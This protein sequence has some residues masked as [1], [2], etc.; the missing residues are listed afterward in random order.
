MRPPPIEQVV[1]LRDEMAN[2]VWAVERIV[3][4]AAGAGIDGY[5]YADAIAGPLPPE[6]AP[7]PG[8][9]V[10]YRLGSDVVWNW[11]PFIPVHVPGSNRSVRLQRARLPHETSAQT[12]RPIVG[13]IIAGP[14]PFFL[15][16][17]EVPRAGRVVTREFRRA[18][19]KDGA[20]VLWIGRRTF[21]G[22][23][24]GSSGLVFDDLKPVQKQS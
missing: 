17:E 18:R 8:S 3:P 5:A 10:R 9:E 21:T 24:E 19:S 13:R 7:A 16:E 14:T 1:L 22:R 20:V 11:H 12:S 23:G 6:P 2:L 15:N 4:S